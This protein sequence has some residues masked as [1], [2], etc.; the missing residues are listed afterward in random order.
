MPEI[1]EFVDATA[2]L[3]KFMS[4]VLAWVRL[5]A[6]LSADLRLVLLL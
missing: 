5:L 2:P 6:A 3:R 1:M 4:T